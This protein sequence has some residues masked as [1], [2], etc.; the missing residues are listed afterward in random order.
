MDIETTVVDNV[1]EHQPTDTGFTSPPE[2]GRG[3]DANNALNPLELID[4]LSL[5]EITIARDGNDQ[6][7]LNLDKSTVIYDVMERASPLMEDFNRDYFDLAMGVRIL[8][9]HTDLSTEK[10]F[11]FAFFMRVKSKRWRKNR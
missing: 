9:R 4:E 8:S 11:T 2:E 3:V 1:E 6:I 10:V 5:L 7:S